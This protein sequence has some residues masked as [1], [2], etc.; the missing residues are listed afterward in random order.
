MEKILSL[1]EKNQE[2]SFLQN[3]VFLTFFQLFKMTELIDIFY[4]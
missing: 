4:F 3:K 2:P 1:Q